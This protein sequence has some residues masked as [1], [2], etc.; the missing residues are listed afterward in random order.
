MDVRAELWDPDSDLLTEL[1]DRVRDMAATW[2]PTTELHQ[3]YDRQGRVLEW[4]VW[5][6]VSSVDESMVA[7]YVLEDVTY[8]RMPVEPWGIDITTLPR[9][10]YHPASYTTITDGPADPDPRV[11][12]LSIEDSSPDPVDDL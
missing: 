9:Y 2:R 1:I 10:G 3:T 5:S 7:A 8:R 11:I 6:T 12:M 4:M